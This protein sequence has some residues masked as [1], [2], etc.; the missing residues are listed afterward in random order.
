MRR[1]RQCRRGFTL[2]EVVIA[3][4]VA[5]ILVGAL[6]VAVD[7]QLRYAQMSRDTIQNSTLERAVLAGMDADAAQVVG[8]CDPARFR[9]SSGQETPQTVPTTGGANANGS[10]AATGSSSANTSS[11][12]NTSSASGTNSSAS[13][14]TTTGANG[15]TDV[16]SSFGSTSAVTNSSGTTNI[17]LPLGVMGDSQ[18]L[19]LFISNLPREIYRSN[20]A[21][22]NAAAGNTPPVSDI[23]RVS[24]W[25][26]GGGDGPG[27]LARQEISLSTSDDA[28]ENLPPDVDN[29]NSFIIADEVR[30]LQFQYWDGTQ[31][32]D[33]WDSTEVGPDG[34]T[35]IGS[36]LA[37][38]VT[39][40][41]APKQTGP[42][43]SDAPI[44]TVRHILVIPSANGMTLQTDEA[45]GTSL[46]TTTSSNTTNSNSTTNG[47]GASP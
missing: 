35:P 20:A 46:Q 14:S 33:S 1:Q 47:G 37:V 42:A 15:S 18:S 41:F 27:G 6:Y 24:Y 23:R 30:S 22:A 11:S 34:V 21:F 31:W 12:S 19:H 9:F 16:Q 44:H 40:G 2:L 13:S 38:A 10:G 36:P 45:T 43:Q 3:L 4:A 7:L 17:V 32:E 25:L 5:A 29:E 39:I 8:L 26:V 28:L